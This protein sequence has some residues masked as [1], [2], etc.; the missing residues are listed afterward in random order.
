MYHHQKQVKNIKADRLQ[1][2]IIVLYNQCCGSALISIRI[3]VIKLWEK[4]SILKREHPAL[5]NMKFLHF[6]LFLLATFMIYP[7]KIRAGS[8]TL[9]VTTQY[10]A[11]I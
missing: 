8:T 9:A 11:I 10:L 5:E 7:P 2:T 1:L 4:P 6:L 3:L